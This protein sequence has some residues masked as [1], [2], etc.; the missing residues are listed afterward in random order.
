[1]TKQ[2]EADLSTEQ[3]DLAAIR[4]FDTAEHL[5]DGGH[6]DDAGYH[7]GICGENAVKSAMREAGLEQ[8]W[9]S[10]GQKALNKSPMRGH[11]ADLAAK[12]VAAS[13]EI[14]VFAIGRRANALRTLAGSNIAVFD[15]WHIDIRYANPAYVPVKPVSLMGWKN[16]AAQ[17]VANFV[18]LQ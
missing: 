17:F 2:G 14:N 1:M 10:L 4:H 8:Y 3:F 13:N 9:R 12:I 18:V 6:H 7:Y 5:E 11:W 16:D 15:G